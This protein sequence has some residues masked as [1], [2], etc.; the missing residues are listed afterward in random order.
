MYYLC[1][2]QTH[3]LYKLWH[4][5][6]IRPFV[7]HRLKFLLEMVEIL[8]KNHY[9]AFTYRTSYITLCRVRNMVLTMT[10]GRRDERI[11]PRTLTYGDIY[12]EWNVC[13]EVP[14]LA[15][16]EKVIKNRIQQYDIRKQRH[17]SVSGDLEQDLWKIRKELYKWFGE[18]EMA[19]P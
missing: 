15:D 7:N 6:Y 16:A 1:G 8:L 12:D 11:N 2:D 5:W 18:A 10:S 17:L 13:M 4:K 3:L 9:T 19:D 14:D